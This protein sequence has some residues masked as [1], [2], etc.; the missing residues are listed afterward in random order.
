MLTIGDVAKA[1]GLSTARVNQLDAVLRPVR[2]EN[3]HRRYAAADVERLM[4]ERSKR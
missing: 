1:L 2:R 4:K 3:G